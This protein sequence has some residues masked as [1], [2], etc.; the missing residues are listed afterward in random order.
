MTPPSARA[1]RRISIIVAGALA[2]SSLVFSVAPASAADAVDP[3]AVAGADELRPLELGVPLVIGTAAV[4]QQVLADHGRSPVADYTYE[5]LADG[6]PIPGQT[7][8]VLTVS[9]AVAGKRISFRVEGTARGFLTTT[10]TSLAT[11]R[12]TLPVRATLRGLEWPGNTMTMSPG[13]WPTGTTLKYQW[14]MNGR[15]ISGATGTKLAV[16][17]DG[18]GTTISVLVTAT[19]PGYE[20]VAV[21][22]QFSPASTAVYPLRTVSAVSSEFPAEQETGGLGGIVIGVG[23]KNT[24]LSGAR[25]RVYS[26]GSGLAATN[27]ALV[28]DLLTDSAG[29]FSVS[30]LAPGSYCT[31]VTSPD[32]RFASVDNCHEDLRWDGVRVFARATADATVGLWPPGR[33]SGTVSA[34]NGTKVSGGTVNV[35]RQYTLASGALGLYKVASTRTDSAGRYSIAGLEAGYVQVE[36]TGATSLTHQTVWWT[37]TPELMSSPPTSRSAGG[38]SIEE[39][40]TTTANMTLPAYLPVGVPVVKGAVRVGAKL[41]ASHPK[42]S[43]ATYAYQWYANG[44]ALKGA[45]KQ[46]LTLAGGQAGKAVTVK[47]VGKRKGYAT[48]TRTSAATAKVLTTA[49]P[50]VSGTLKVGRT[51]TATPG[52]WTSGTRFTYQW[53]VKGKPVAGAT[54]KTYVLK[55]ADRAHRVSVKVTGRKTGYATNARAS[56]SSR[57]VAR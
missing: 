37:L 44:A 16:P 48:T 21:D 45:T 49:Q 24:N 10:A 34:S 56:A 17:Y 52:K 41:T 31:V 29:R 26:L 43:G 32:A 5:W 55:A 11:P 4:G 2:A 15:A 57:L 51:L 18:G 7:D 23:V 19:R 22:S 42:T 20:T 28:A 50:R 3:A 1:L 6:V 13:A 27:G 36:F 47:V 30:D 12:V 33:L 38:V 14:L 25:V 54:K 9:S 40:E 35:Y 8:S 39:N 46:T 53:Y